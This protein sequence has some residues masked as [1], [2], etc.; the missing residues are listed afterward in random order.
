MVQELYGANMMIVKAIGMRSNIFY[1]QAF[2]E[3]T[4][5]LWT[6]RLLFI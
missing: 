3:R 5:L 2:S 6:K 4:K 1:L